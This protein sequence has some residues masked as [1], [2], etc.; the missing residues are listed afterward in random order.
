MCETQHLAVNI[1][2]IRVS[3]F[4]RVETSA[5]VTLKKRLRRILVS[6]LTRIAEE[7]GYREPESGVS[8]AILDEKRGDYQGEQ[9]SLA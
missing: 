4:V 1:A 6:T 8:P 9:T 2:G 5:L 7:M 3:I